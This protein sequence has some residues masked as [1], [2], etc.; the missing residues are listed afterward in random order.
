MFAEA[1][2]RCQYFNNA[3]RKRA[4]PATPAM[5]PAIAP[6]CVAA[7]LLLLATLLLP[8]QAP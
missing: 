8:A 1:F 4:R 3:K 2:W 7:L 6:A 5:L